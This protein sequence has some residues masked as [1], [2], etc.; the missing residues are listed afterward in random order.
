MFKIKFFFIILT[1]ENSDENNAKYKANITMK[2]DM[3]YADSEAQSQESHAANAI[4]AT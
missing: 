1:G 4:T 3:R 2:P